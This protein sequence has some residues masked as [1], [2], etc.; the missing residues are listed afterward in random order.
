VTLKSTAHTVEMA[1]ETY[2]LDNGD[3]PNGENLNAAAL[4]EILI[5]AGVMSSVPTNPFTGSAVSATDS[6]G[7]L[8][9]SKTDTGYTLL[10]YGSNTDTPIETISR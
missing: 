9:Y 4:S 7:L 5:Q 8:D 2:V 1:L 3:Y 6:K 10:V